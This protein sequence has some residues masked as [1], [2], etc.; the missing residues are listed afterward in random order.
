M[1]IDRTFLGLIE[2][3]TFR[4]DRLCKYCINRRLQLKRILASWFFIL[5]AY[6]NASSD[7]TIISN[8]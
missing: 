4:V 8:A 7:K 3:V 1:P 2:N 5:K 6:A